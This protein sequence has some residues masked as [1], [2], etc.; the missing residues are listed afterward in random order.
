[1]TKRL[2]VR[3]SVEE[4][5]LSIFSFAAVRCECRLGDCGTG[6]DG[7]GVI[8]RWSYNKVSYQTRL[9]EQTDL[10]CVEV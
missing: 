6:H 10:P 8:E 1:V 5:S 2:Q 7:F 9:P 4:G 3:D